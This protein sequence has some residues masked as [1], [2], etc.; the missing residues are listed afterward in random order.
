MNAINTGWTAWSGRAGIPIVDTTREPAIRKPDFFILGAP[1]A[2][3]T[4]LAEWLSAHPQIYFSPRK[5]PHYFNTDGIA[6]TARLADYERLF[7]EAD[8]RHVAVGEGSTHYLYSAT[9]VPRILEYQ[10]DA[11]FIVSVRNPLEMAP[12]LH[13]ECLRQGWET[14]R[15]F[16]RAWRLQD[17]RRRG[18]S[19]PT[20][21]CG[22]PDRLLYGPYA[23]L[24]EQLERLYQ[25]VGSDQVKVILVDDLRRDPGAVYRAVLE[26]LDV[27]DD[28][29]TAF[30]TLNSAPHTRSVL[31]SQL[32]RRTSMLRDALWR[33][34]DW[35]LA[36]A[37]R[38]INTRARDRAALDEAMRAEL[39]DYFADD[40]D[41]LGRL[42]NRD[43]SA[44]L[45]QPSGE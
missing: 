33:P 19:V 11:R 23:R 32:I 30:P 6:G 17:A 3:T 35:G 38:R 9:A 20:P 25:R 29:R 8:D 41:R 14:V 22:D 36:A 16:E 27:K 28:G 34:G 13:D 31:L 42:L 44:W 10:P 1:K 37:I 15:R 21:A 26:F 40:V 43:L 39:C 24:G 2:A 18:Q 5:E 45:D 4:A 7:A 12:A